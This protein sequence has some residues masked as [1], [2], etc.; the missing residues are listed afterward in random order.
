METVERIS[1]KKIAWRGVLNSITQIIPF[2]AN[3]IGLCYGGFM[4]SNNEIQYK[5]VIK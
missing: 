4:V 3:G 2:V 1:R 5:N